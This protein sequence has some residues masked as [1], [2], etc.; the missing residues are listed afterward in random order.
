MPIGADEWT[1]ATR[2]WIEP[3]ANFS[4]PPSMPEM[5]ISGSD[6]MRPDGKKPAV[7][8]VTGLLN[9]SD[10]SAAGVPLSLGTDAEAVG[11]ESW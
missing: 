2:W 5:V 11:P 6:V 3:G 1:V 8:L 7:G 4:P 10:G 9:V